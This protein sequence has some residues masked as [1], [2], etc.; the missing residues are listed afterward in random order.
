MQFNKNKNYSFAASPSALNIV[1]VYSVLLY[2]FNLPPTLLTIQ[3]GMRNKGEIGAAS[4]QA[5]LGIINQGYSTRFQ[6][7]SL[8]S[9]IVTLIFTYLVGYKFG[10]GLPSNILELL[11]TSIVLHISLLLISVQ[12]CLS[13]VTASSALFHNFEKY[14]DILKEE[15]CKKYLIRLA[16]LLLLLIISEFVPNF[17]DLILIL[18]G[19]ITS[20]LVFIFPPILLV[21]FK[22]MERKYENS[23]IHSQYG[24]IP[25]DL[26][27]KSNEQV[28]EQSTQCRRIKRCCFD[29]IQRIQNS[30]TLLP[31]MIIFG[32][33]GFASATYLNLFE[34]RVML[35]NT[36]AFCFRLT[37]F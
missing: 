37:W 8:V 29:G 27:F 33:I 30:S 9:G 17:N 18:G 25:L 34:V 16:I 4:C 6:I 15:Y 3:S 1:T 2:Q 13:S 20:P 23:V 7:V 11:P 12:L 10:L 32:V 21:K 24:S 19:T 14:F 31:A 36:S 26:N 28:E 22:K 35:L 5:F